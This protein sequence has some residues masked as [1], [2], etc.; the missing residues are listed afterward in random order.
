MSAKLEEKWHH[1]YNK[2]RKGTEE[3][4]GRGGKG[5]GQGSAGTDVKK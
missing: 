5:W 1:H 4:G 3:D 2:G